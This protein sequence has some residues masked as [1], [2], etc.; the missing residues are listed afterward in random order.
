MSN[1]NPFA[2]RYATLSDHRLLEVVARKQDYA[3]EAVEAALLEIQRRGITETPSQA[4]IQ[5]EGMDTSSL[6]LWNRF[7]KHLPWSHTRFSNEFWVSWTR[8][9]VAINVIFETYLA[10]HSLL[11]GNFWQFLTEEQ[12]KLYVVPRLLLYPGA[13]LFLSGKRVGWVLSTLSVTFIMFHDYNNAYWSGQLSLL[14]IE[15]SS[16]VLGPIWIQLEHFFNKGA[17]GLLLTI[18]LWISPVRQHF[19]VKKPQI[20]LALIA[21]ILTWLVLVELPFHVEF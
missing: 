2:E 14:G 8:W 9:V 20:L 19:T 13:L 15:A 4:E 17:L 12:L 10:R 6:P 3:P 1:P 7:R 21:V 16:S 18:L 5:D 11:D